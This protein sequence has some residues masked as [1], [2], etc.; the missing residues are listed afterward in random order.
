VFLDDDVLPEADWTEA[1]HRDL[2][3]ATD[4]VAANQAT[5]VVPLP[6]DRRP[7]DWERNTA[8]LRTAWWI[9]ADMAYR[10]DVLTEVGGFD[11]V[12]PRAYREDADLALRVRSRGYLLAQGT[13]RTT[14]PVRAAGFF[15]SVRAQ[16]GNADNA[17]LRRKYGP[18]WR[19]QIG[20]GPGR[21]RQHLLTTVAGAMALLLIGAGRRNWAAASAGTWL[22][23]TSEFAFR[24]IT[25]GPCTSSEL[26]RMAITSAVI[27]PL[28]CWHRLRGE[29]RAAQQAREDSR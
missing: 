16:Q 8:G 2:L 7:T 18:N 15:A 25:A 26:A 13:R 28:A 6:A 24:R 17:V 1:L 3:T 19:Q 5:I 21:I 11:E 27:P 4:D 9:T 12:F 23:L 22:A 10:R 29:L 14:H 20:E